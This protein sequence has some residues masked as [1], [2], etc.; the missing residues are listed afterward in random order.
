[1]TALDA[2]YAGYF[3][4]ERYRYLSYRHSI[5]NFLHAYTRTLSVFAED[6]GPS[7]RTYFD[8][9]S[10]FDSISLR[11]DIPPKTRSYM[12]HELLGSIAMNCSIEDVERYKE[13]YIQLTGDSIRAKHTLLERGITEVKN[14]D[15]VLRS[16]TGNEI[17]YENLRKQYQGKVLYVDFW[18]SWCAPCR[19]VMPE[20][21]KL[22]KEYENKDVVFLYLAFNDRENEWKAAINKLQLN[23]KRAI[24]YF[25][26]NSKS[27]KAIQELKVESIP[28]YLIYDKTGKIVHYRA[29]GPYGTEIR[30]QL[31]KLLKE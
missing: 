18:A 28:R 12:L 11:A 5:D 15:I 1:M 20:A 25:I 4:D 16:N 17:N 29:P 26:V 14:E 24:N 13:K 23:D 9:R 27:S 7:E 19:S 22:R 3:D 21:L 31:D 2:I 6:R 8:Y 10:V 30:E